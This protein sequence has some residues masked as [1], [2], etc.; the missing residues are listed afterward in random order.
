MPE[1]KLAVNMHS[2]R[3]VYGY[4]QDYVSSQ[5]HVA[6]Q[7]YSNYERGKKLP[8]I[9][10]LLY[11]AELYQISVD[12][13]TFPGLLHPAALLRSHQRPG[14]AHHGYGE[15]CAVRPGTGALPFHIRRVV[16]EHRPAGE[17]VGQG[18]GKGQKRGFVHPH[19]HQP[20]G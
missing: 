11:L 12:Q 9:P 8:D 16:P 14:R 15:P 2:L 5:I 18:H 1:I 7:T 19:P 17:F 10:T 4:S 6:R 3:D 13:G 20:A